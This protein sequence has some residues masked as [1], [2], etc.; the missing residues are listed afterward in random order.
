[1]RTFVGVSRVVTTAMTVAL[2]VFGAGCQGVPTCRDIDALTEDVGGDG[3]LDVA[4]PTGVVFDPATTIKFRGGNTLVPADLLPHVEEVNLD[5]GLARFL[6][7]S[8]SFI[9]RFSLTLDYGDA[10]VQT[11]CDTEAFNAFELKVEAACPVNTELSVEV[12]AVLPIGGGIPVATIPIGL[13]TDAAEFACG[14]T[15]SLVTTKNEAG[16]VV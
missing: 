1:M 7:D 3:F 11:I 10:G 14:Q 13:T 8:T 15:V 4:P 16:E 9:V 6:V 5:P 12:I 2:V